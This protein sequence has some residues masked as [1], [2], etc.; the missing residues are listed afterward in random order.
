MPRK[1]QEDAV[2]PKVPEATE[3]TTPKDAY[4]Q[5]RAQQ[6]KLYRLLPKQFPKKEEEKPDTA[7]EA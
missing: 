4:I 1:K 6:D 2:E 5:W 7:G 3:E